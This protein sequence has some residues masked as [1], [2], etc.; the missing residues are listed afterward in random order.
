MLQAK[1]INAGALD[2]QVTIQSYTET[3]STTGSVIKTWAT[4]H[5]CWAE[6]HARGGS[7]RVEAA[8]LT[9]INNVTWRIRYKS[10][11][12]EKMRI[13]D[14]NSEYYYI[15][16]IA[17]EGRDQWMLLTTEKRD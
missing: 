5:S 16:S 1:Y 17:I 14:R 6:R 9:A 10:T 11:V 3:R 2:E 8:Q 15:T 4:H 13:L 12:T 7:E